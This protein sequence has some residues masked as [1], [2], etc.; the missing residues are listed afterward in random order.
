ML[1]ATDVD[2]LVG[3]AGRT[4]LIEVK[5]PKRA[6]ESKIKPIQK[7]LR[8]TWRGHYAIVTTPEQALAAVGLG[9]ELWEYTIL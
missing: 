7:I 8:D 1:P 5:H 9:P 2:L 4:Y 6:S 3:R